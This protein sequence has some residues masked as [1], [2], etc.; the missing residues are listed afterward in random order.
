MSL[1][2]IIFSFDGGNSKLIVTLTVID[3]DNPTDE[4]SEFMS[5]GR[6]QQIV[7]ARGD[8]APENLHN[9]RIILSKLRIFDE[10]HFNREFMVTGDLKVMNCFTGCILLVLNT[11]KSL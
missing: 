3:L 11:L 8:Y 5:N 10:S 6:R 2:Y 7:I 9:W 4:G 1:K